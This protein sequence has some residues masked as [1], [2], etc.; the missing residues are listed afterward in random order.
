MYKRET[1]ETLHVKKKQ[2]KITFSLHKEPVLLIIAF[3]LVV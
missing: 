2:K 1:S 3:E